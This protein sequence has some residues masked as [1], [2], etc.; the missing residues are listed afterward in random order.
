MLE[1]NTITNI[2]Q[3]YFKKELDIYWLVINNRGLGQKHC[4]WPFFSA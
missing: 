3:P 2:L 4:F 1:E